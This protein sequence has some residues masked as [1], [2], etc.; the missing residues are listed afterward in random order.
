MFRGGGVQ[1]HV[2]AQAAELQKRGH[3]VKIITPKPRGYA[4][5]PPT[6]MLFVGDST[7]FKTPISTNAEVGMNLSRKAIEEV[8]KIEKF[9][10]LHVHE[11][12]VPVLGSQIVSRADCP[13]VATFHAMMPPTTVARTIEAFRVTYSRALF[14]R[15]AAVTAVSDVAANFVREHT[16]HEVTIIP[17]G[18]DL[19]KYKF[20][21]KATLGKQLSILY[22]GRLEKR[23]GVKHLLEAFEQLEEMRPD[24]KLQLTIVGDGPQR[25]ML[26][27]FAK[28]H[29]LKNVDFEGFVTE[30]RK[31]ELLSKANIFCSPALYGESFGI[32]LLEAMARGVVAV[33][34]NNP[35]YESLMQGTGRLSIVNP[36]DTDEFARRLE[37]FLTNQELRKIWLVWA[38]D[39]VK[40]FDYPKVVDQ[41]EKLYKQ[42]LKKK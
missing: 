12:E 10:L 17:N 22:I 20:T 1:E 35:G 42:V 24:L 39:Y 33:A 38:K 40:Q 7:N 19:V 27:S 13:V 30:K 36:K 34:G 11:P 37:L 31:L 32:V 21:G 23:K 4:E 18:I 2:L 41:Y 26:E 28:D 9:D 3:D 8:L 25:S 15:L 5:D 14:N 16:D 29:G 6:N